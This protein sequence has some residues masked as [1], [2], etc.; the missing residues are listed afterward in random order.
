[1]EL[2]EIQKQ[3]EKVEKAYYEMKATKEVVE[4]TSKEQVEK[5]ARVE[6]Q[7][8]GDA[9]KITEVL[10]DLTISGALQEVEEQAASPAESNAKKADEVVPTS[11]SELASKQA[12]TSHEATSVEKEVLDA[13]VVF[14][15]NSDVAPINY[16]VLGTLT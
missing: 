10:V 7:A 15:S 16:V 11:L 1:M 4:N 13:V 12:D 3:R 6:Q 5:E 14:S 9:T 2:C 8:V